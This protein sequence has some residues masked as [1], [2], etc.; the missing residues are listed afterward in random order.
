MYRSGSISTSVVRLDSQ[1]TGFTAWSHR[2]TFAS[3]IVPTRAAVP[4]ASSLIAPPY[5]PYEARGHGPLTLLRPGTG[6]VTR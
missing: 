4:A 1:N 6:R 5:G 3:T 2:W